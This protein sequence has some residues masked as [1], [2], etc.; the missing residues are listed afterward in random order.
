MNYALKFLSLYTTIVIT[1]CIA[2]NASNTN[3]DLLAL[4]TTTT[5]APKNLPIYHPNILPFIKQI[6]YVPS[7]LNQS[8]KEKVQDKLI[9]LAIKDTS[10]SDISLSAEEVA[11]TAFLKGR[12]SYRGPK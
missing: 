11:V 8:E 9:T 1:Y 3:A 6:D 5:N 12:R 4:I 10:P 7:T 2:A